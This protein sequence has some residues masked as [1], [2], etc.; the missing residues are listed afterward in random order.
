MNTYIHTV[1]G[2]EDIEWVDG[3]RAVLTAQRSMRA[4]RKR[5]S[6]RLVE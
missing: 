3:M 4:C 6:A 2:W 5:G 1:D